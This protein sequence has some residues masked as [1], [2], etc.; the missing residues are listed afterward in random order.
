MQFVFSAVIKLPVNKVLIPSDDKVGTE[1]ARIT[2]PK[3]V[4]ELAEKIQK[5][6]MNYGVDPIIVWITT[7][8]EEEVKRLLLQINRELASAGQM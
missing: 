1:K 8:N 2:R 3:R 4:D 5:R 6:G 7:E